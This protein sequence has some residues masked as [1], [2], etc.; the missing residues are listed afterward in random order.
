M[1]YR[2]D[3]V[4]LGEDQRQVYI[5]ELLKEKD[6]VVSSSIQDIKEAK[7]IVG[8]TPCI[9]EKALETKD[10]VQKG[11]IFFAGCI[12][13]QWKERILEKGVKVFDFMKNKQVVVANSVATAEGVIAK[14]I[15]YSTGNVR[16]S[17]CLVL[18]YG[19]CGKT[20]VATLKGMGAKVIVCT[21]EK[22]ER[23]FAKV[24]VDEVVDLEQLELVLA[25]SDYIFNTIPKRIL[26]EKQLQHI[27]QYS[28]VLDI[29][30]NQGG[31]DYMAAKQMG[32][33]A[34]HC[35]ALPAQY[36]PRESANILVQ[37][38]MEQIKMEK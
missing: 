13:E 9:E 18:G 14:A 27:K 35:K 26:L 10:Y 1:P 15:E 3:F 5:R 16:G 17:T 34:Y 32:V 28:I 30:S 23:A 7:M 25:K 29:A 19:V 36:A 31:V 4:V 21:R 8:S 12:S 37:A 33:A 38:M 24:V 11:Q 22:E 2:Y 20:I 6:Y